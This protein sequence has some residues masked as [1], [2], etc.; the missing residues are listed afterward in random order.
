V[1]ERQNLLCRI[2]GAR[3]E[4][5]MALRQHGDGRAEHEPDGDSGKQRYEGLPTTTRA[6][7]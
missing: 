7:G 2:E 4:H 5:S 3:N 1:G 6:P